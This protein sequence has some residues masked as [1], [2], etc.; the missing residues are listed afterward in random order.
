MGLQIMSH[1]KERWMYKAILAGLTC[2]PFAFSAAALAQTCGTLPYNLSNGTTADANQVM[3]NFNFILNCIKQ[4]TR[5][6]LTSGSGT[7]STPGGAVRLY[8]RMVGGGGG[9]G[10]SGTS[11]AGAGT[12]GGNTTFG[13]NFLIA[14]GG[15]AGSVTSGS[16]PGG[17]ATGGSVNLPGGSSGPSSGA[18]LPGGAG[19][20]SA[21]GGNGFGGDVDDT[22]KNAVGFG[23]GGG[24]AGAATSSTTPAGGAAGGYLEQVIR[25]PA[26]TYPYAVGA[27]GSGG[28]AGASGFI[29]GSGATGV[30]I[31]DE[32]YY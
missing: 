17:I 4:P 20:V 24:G 6:V 26:A 5:T 2:L 16:V 18:F 12:I 21:F 19:G 15:S 32:Y 8:V 10:G 29:G 31:I 30:I 1:N 3:A 22:G 14:Y 25:L 28:M 27:G 11:S 23:S 9:G 7:Y 13:T